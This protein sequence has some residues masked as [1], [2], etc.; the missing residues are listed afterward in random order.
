MPHQKIAAFFINE[1]IRVFNVLFS[2]ATKW[3]GMGYLDLLITHTCR[4]LSNDYNYPFY[5]KH[6]GK[7][8]PFG[9]DLR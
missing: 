4:E 3:F 9:L 8:I 6:L 5:Y 2:Q 7:N 1:G